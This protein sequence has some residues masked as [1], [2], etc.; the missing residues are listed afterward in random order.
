M[1]ETINE[2]NHYYSFE[3]YARLNQDELNAKDYSYIIAALM[4]LDTI[5]KIKI[6]KQIA[7]YES[8]L[9]QGGK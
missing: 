3:L 1:L 6:D 4:Q 8:I 7:F 9:A 2:N 5:E